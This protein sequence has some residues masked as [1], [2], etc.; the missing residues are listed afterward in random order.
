MVFIN[1]SFANNTNNT[2]QISFVIAIA[3]NSNN[4]NIIYWSFI[5]YKKVTYLILAFKL[6]AIAYRFNYGAVLKSIIEKILQVELPLVLYIDF[7]SLYKC[8]IKLEST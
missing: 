3:D 4:I 8:L 2:L 5:K 1:T 7:K 6:Y